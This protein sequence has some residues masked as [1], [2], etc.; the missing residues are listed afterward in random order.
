MLSLWKLLCTDVVDFSNKCQTYVSSANYLLSLVQYKR[1]S[2]I[3]QLNSRDSSLQLRLL[4][5]NCI[6]I[7]TR[8][9]MYTQPSTHYQALYGITYT[10]KTAQNSLN[11]MIH[12]K[13]DHDPVKILT[14]GFTN[15]PFILVSVICDLWRE[16]MEGGQGA[17]WGLRWVA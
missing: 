9:Y 14:Y 13:Y 4:E 17:C 5:G 1:C 11:S 3:E 8:Y 15:A 16:V 10:P 6:T 2:R 7:A 12:L